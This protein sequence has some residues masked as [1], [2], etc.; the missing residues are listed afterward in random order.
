MALFCSFLWLSSI[1]LYIYIYHIF[2]IQSLVHGHLGCVQVLA[3]VNSAAMNI[4]EHISFVVIVLF[5]YVPR[6][7][8]VGSYGSS[9]L[10]IL[11][12]IH[13]DFHSCC[14][15]YIPTDSKEVSLF[16]TPCPTFVVC[17]LFNVGHSGWCKMS[18][19]LIFDS[20]PFPGG[21]T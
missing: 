13:A 17:R 16:S 10:G 9:I 12:N 4:V 7:G 14:T 6:S 20:V 5:G 2:L 15:T 18:R 11:R 19:T 8:I 1:L 21:E 3:I